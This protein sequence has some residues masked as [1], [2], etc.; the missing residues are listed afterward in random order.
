VRYINE[1]QQ[2]FVSTYFCLIFFGYLPGCRPRRNSKPVPHHDG[3]DRWSYDLPVEGR[4][5]LSL[6][7]QFASNHC[8]GAAFLQHNSDTGSGRLL[9]RL[10]DGSEVIVRRTTRLQGGTAFFDGSELPPIAS[11]RIA[12][13]SKAH[14]R[15]RARF[16]LGT[17][18]AVIAVRGPSSTWKSAR[19]MSR[20]YDVVDGLS[21]LWKKY[22]T[23]E[24][25]LLE[26][27]FSTRIGMDSGPEQPEPTNEIRPEVEDLNLA[28]T[29]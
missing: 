21:K 7:G 10:S 26:P 27:G 12:R 11:G 17:P 24:S 1:I 5:A 9:L 15:C 6:P 14:W 2:P 20:K 16:E 3:C 23:E 28:R 29:K 18:S 4:F 25:V 19:A 22:K 13:S 8:V